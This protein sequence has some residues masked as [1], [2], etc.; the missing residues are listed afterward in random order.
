LSSLI[1]NKKLPHDILEID[2]GFKLSSSL[3]FPT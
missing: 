3:K 2:E 1:L